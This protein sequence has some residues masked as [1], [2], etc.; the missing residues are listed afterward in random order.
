MSLLGS[1]MFSPKLTKIGT[2]WDYHQTRD[3][4]CGHR[5][6]SEDMGF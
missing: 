5:A 1:Q 4:T 3:I 6:Q 2:Q